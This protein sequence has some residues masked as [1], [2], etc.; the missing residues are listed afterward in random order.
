MSAGITIFLMFVAFIYLMFQ[1]PLLFW[2][3][4]FPVTLF[5]IIN[6]IVWLKK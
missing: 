4:I 3:L 1:N 2:L 5:L 6:F